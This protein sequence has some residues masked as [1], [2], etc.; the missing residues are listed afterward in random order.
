MSKILFLTLILF[1]ILLLTNSQTWSTVQAPEGTSSQTENYAGQP[2][3]W[4]RPRSNTH[5]IINSYMFH[6]QTVTDYR[7]GDIYRPFTQV[8]HF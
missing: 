5:F 2:L 8:K 4:D 7:N 1:K 6:T 3:W